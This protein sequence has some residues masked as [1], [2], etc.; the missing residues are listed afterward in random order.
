[1]KA[2]TLISNAVAI[3]LV[4]CSPRLT[5][6]HQIESPPL[7]ST[8]RQEVVDCSGRD[9]VC[10][11]RNGKMVVEKLTGKDLEFV[12]QDCDQGDG[13][14]PAEPDYDAAINAIR[15]YTKHPDLELTPLET[16]CPTR[17]TWY[18][19]GNDCW[20]VDN[21]TNRVLTKEK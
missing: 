2:L 19:A 9:E 5:S 18:C 16:K 13:P 8:P 21:A 15:A 10:V 20:A 11:I 17:T 6:N 3:V 4:A 7:G 14:S 1:M 12:G